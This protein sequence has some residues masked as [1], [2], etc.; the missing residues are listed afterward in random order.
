MHDQVDGGAS[1]GRHTRMG[2]LCVSNG[3]MD[4]IVCLL[5]ATVWVTGSHHNPFG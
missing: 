4:N 5:G 2:D 3:A 1:N